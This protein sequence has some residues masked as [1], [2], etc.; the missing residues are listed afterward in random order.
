MPWGGLLGPELFDHPF[1]VELEQSRIA[2]QEARGVDATWQYIEPA[3]IDREDIFWI[4]A[5]VIGG[6]SRRQT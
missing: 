5:Q 6:F 2:A 3:L 1:L 4:N